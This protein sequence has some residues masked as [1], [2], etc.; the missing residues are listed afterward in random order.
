M[1]LGTKTRQ[2]K[3]KLEVQTVRKEKQTVASG[4]HDQRCLAK[5][6]SSEKG[7]FTTQL[8]TLQNKIDQLEK[9]KTE[10][11]ILIENL[12]NKIAK[13]ETKKQVE[14]ASVECQTEYE[15][16]DIPCKDCIY[17]ASCL[18]ELNWH[19]END[20]ADEDCEISESIQL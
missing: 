4:K 8:K 3:R 12:K 20:H 11:E 14:T 1:V 10:S 7:V 17:V 18:D 9:E 16:Q 2:A 13:K 19:I 6:N 15:F 5:D